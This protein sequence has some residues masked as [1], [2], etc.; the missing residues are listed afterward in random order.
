MILAFLQNAYTSDEAQAR[1]NED[2]RRD[3]RMVS[4]F[5]HLLR[6]AIAGDHPNHT[7][8]RLRNALHPDIC[9][10]IWWENASPRWGWYSGQ[11]FP[12]DYAHIRG[13]LKS[14]S[15]EVVLA[16]GRVASDALKQIRIADAGS[17]QLI[18]G[19]H[20]AA[21]GSDVPHRLVEMRVRLNQTYAFEPCPNCGL[22]CTGS[23][24]CEHCYKCCG[25]E[26]GGR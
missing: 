6:E 12:A 2:A 25:Q 8:R 16:F 3:E 14:H 20:P 24:H 4:R 7:Y 19:P 22:L 17:W 1:R 23:S 26:E 18:V 13:L 15:P 5:Q 11:K 21:R 10:L 9:R